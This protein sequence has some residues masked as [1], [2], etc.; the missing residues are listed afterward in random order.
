MFFF[1]FGLSLYRPLGSAGGFDPADAR[2]RW[3]P[4]AQVNPTAITLTNGYNA[5]TLAP[6]ED[7]IITSSAL[8]NVGSDVEVTG[9]RHVRFVKTARRGRI[10]VKQLSGSVLHPQ[11][12]S[13]FHQRANLL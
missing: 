6:W 1:G 8:G 10:N 13:A 12:A 5:I 4:P 3:Q 2:L 11:N 7:A 9:G